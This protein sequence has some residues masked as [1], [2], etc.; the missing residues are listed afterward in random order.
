MQFLLL[1]GHIS[2]QISLIHHPC[3][4]YFSLQITNDANIN[5]DVY[6]PNCDCKDFHLFE[7]VGKLMG[8]CLRGKECLVRS[9]GLHDVDEN[10]CQ[11]YQNDVIWVEFLV[12][13][14]RPPLY[15]GS[16]V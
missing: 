9:I 10:I 1:L 4:K 5:R 2:K 3:S 12:S 13:P 8:A 14:D 6:L 15:C 7:F 16:S 11:V